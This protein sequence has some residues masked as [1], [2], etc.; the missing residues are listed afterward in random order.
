MSAEA[1]VD[2]ITESLLRAFVAEAGL[3]K[4]TLSTQFEHFAAY[5]VLAP[6]VYE[7]LSTE[8]VIVGQDST[9]GIDAIAVLVNGALV[10]TEDELDAIL[11]AGGAVE[12]EIVFV[13][14]KTS[15]KFSIMLDF[16]AEVKSF[17]TRDE[18]ASSLR[19]ARAVVDRVLGLG[20]RL[21]RNPDCHLFYVTTG[22]W[23]SNHPLDEKVETAR[24]NVESLNYFDLVT[25]SPVDAR[26]LQTSY[27]ATKN[28]ISAQFAFTNRSTISNVDGVSQAFL[29]TLPATELIKIIADEHGD[30]R[31][32]IFEDNVRDFQGLENPV[33]KQIRASIE[34]NPD[35][36]AVLNN[37]VTLVARTGKVI[38]DSFTLDNFQIVNGCQTANVIYDLRDTP[39]IATLAVPLRVVITE[40]D[41]IANN[42]TAATNSQTQVRNE[43]LY[44]LLTFQ[45]SL[46]QYLM[47]FA[48]PK[49]LYFE[50][51]SKQY[52]ASQTVARNRIVTRAQMVKAF[53]STFLDEPHRATGYYTTLYN[54]LDSRLFREDHRLE[55]YYAAAVAQ[56][57]LDVLLR[58]GTLD[59]QFRPA[60]YQILHAARHLALGTSLPPL[61]S[62][63]QAELSDKYAEIL[64]D[65]R[66]SGELFNAA[67]EVI[68]EVAAGSEINRD[69]TKRTTV[70]KEVA[71]KSLE[72]R[73]SSRSASWFLG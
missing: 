48:P 66:K 22:Q 26:K 65:D 52:Q 41:E 47:T 21:K 15:P 69:F 13:Q 53:A 68:V 55:S 29:G 73:A 11:D 12:V 37:G 5:S 17:F 10:P 60:R 9:P 40:D 7:P 19:P 70:T 18:V 54:D 64:W 51:R 45:R 57:K 1:K 61:N 62:K 72:K 49:D 31:R 63:K 36:F 59:G 24:A 46:E 33:N 39:A 43:E 35:R 32:G 56:F 20:L 2:K 16:A 30:L 4:K 58:A 6:K 3:G 34:A 71:D 42:I 67:A 28:Q 25:F 27:R 50:R 14:A 38:G 44:S 23:E 8:Q